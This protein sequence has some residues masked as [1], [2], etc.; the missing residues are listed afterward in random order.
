MKVFLLSLALVALAVLLLCFNI[1]F[2][3]R[4]FPD[5]EISHNMELRKRGII[6][7][8]EEEIRLHGKRKKSASGGCDSS[9]CSD[10]VAGC[11]IKKEKLT[12]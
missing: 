2:R 1:L 10:C 11:S 7:A 3:N 6:C 9:S 4:P 5:G 8:N 12:K